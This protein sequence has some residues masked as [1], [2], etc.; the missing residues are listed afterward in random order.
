MDFAGGIRL[1]K[2]LLAIGAILAVIG[3]AV[4]LLGYK[5]PGIVTLV[6]GVAMLAI[7]F[8]LSKFYR[9]FDLQTSVMKSKRKRAGSEQTAYFSYIII[10]NKLV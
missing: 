10:K 3:L 4:T 8:S 1:S 9:L 7:S 5:V 6:I 2:W